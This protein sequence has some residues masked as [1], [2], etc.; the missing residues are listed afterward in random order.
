[1]KALRTFILTVTISIF[2][3]NIHADTYSWF[4]PSSWGIS[5]WQ[6][7]YQPSTTAALNLIRKYPKSSFIATYLALGVYFN[8][9]RMY[10]E[11]MTP[12]VQAY[13]T[14]GI[15][16]PTEDVPS[17]KKAY[18]KSALLYHPDKNKSPDAEEKF[19]EIGHA[20]DILKK[21]LNFN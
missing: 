13:K 6:N 20:Y 14:L 8:L 21:A 11:K 5:D 19:K 4:Y 17:I 9:R 1:M 18:K 7:I 10:R 2:A 15:M 12:I 16:K 3:Q